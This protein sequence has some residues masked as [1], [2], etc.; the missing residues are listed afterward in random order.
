MAAIT[1]NAGQTLP[2]VQVPTFRGGVRLIEVDAV[3]RDKDGKFVP[4]LRK[5]DF[6]I[7][8]DGLPQEVASVSV[9]NLRVDS[10]GR[11]IEV[12]DDSASPPE[13]PDEV[14][15]VYVLM[16]NSGDPV[17][18]R[19]IARQFVEEFLG[20]T[21]LMAVMHGNRAVTQ[22]LTND[23]ET[24]LAAVDQY[25]FAASNV[26][27]TLKEVA[28]NLNA[29]G[30]R[31][32][33]I[34]LLTDLSLTDFWSRPA[35]REYDDMVRTAVRN[36]VRIYP[37]DPRGFLV[38]F[39]DMTGEATGGGGGPAASGLGQ[40]MEARVMASDTKGIAIVN[41]GNYGGNFRRIV[42]DNSAY[43]MIGF[44][45][46]AEPDGRFHPVKVRV[47]SRTGLSVRSRDGYVASTPDV[48]GS[49]VKLPKNLS[50][51]ARNVLRTDAPPATGIPMEI[52]TAVFQA[53]GY[54]GSV[55]IGCHIPGDVLKLAAKDQIELSYVAVDRWGKIRAVD[56]RAFTL[57]FN[58]ATRA[59][60]QNTGLRL[61]GRLRL[62][63]GRYEIRVAANQPGGASGSAAREIE[64]PDYT[65]LPLSVSDFV[66]ASSRGPTLMTLEDD[67]ILRRA[68][69]DQPTPQRRF[70]SGDTLTTF[71]EI[72]DSHWIL[73]REIG[74]TSVIRAR[75]GRVVLREEDSLA[76]ANR[77]RFYY[78][79]RVPL[80]GFAP[81]EYT[82]TLEAYTRAGVPASASQQ[83]RFNVAD[84]AATN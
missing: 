20:P 81:G 52:L 28:V 45:S 21:D 37:V 38:R 73:S 9:V 74:V 72:Y 79:G 67:S 70:V 40:G 65:E 51:S 49:A 12:E 43:Y 84:A 2:S 64:I 19:R 83:L 33:A 7:L 39:G 71:A 24:L 47:K 76:S 41:T 25:R 62:P 26:I 48:K 27:R 32:K 61:Y 5:D 1:L 22:G 29:V 60:V 36:N 13:S 82:L 8:E 46:S 18:I 35:E 23:R 66:V 34:L 68:L 14:G 6:E 58:D 30:G 59:R 55:L 53:D 57:T 56:R 10:R 11:P 77:G 75:D 44:Y 16:M 50:A 80:G 78:T 17:R 3:V 42:R 63:R 31:R 4:D 69:P 54:N 15:R